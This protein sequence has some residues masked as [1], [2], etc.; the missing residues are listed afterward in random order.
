M[1]KLDTSLDYILYLSQEACFQTRSIL[2]PAAAFITARNT[3]YETM[4]AA[5]RK[6]HKFVIDGEEYVIDN[7]LIQN[8]KWVGNHGTQEIFTHTKICNDLLWY[9]DR[10]EADCYIEMCDKLWCD[11]SVA[12]FCSDFNHIK[13]YVES[14]RKFESAGIKI[15]D[16]FLVLESNNGKLNMPVFDTVSEMMEELYAVKAE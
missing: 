14:K 5:A 11:L 6:N 1:E 7:L 4:K 9:A 13:N 2:I 10:R 12:G 8:Y 3:D 16:G 15:V